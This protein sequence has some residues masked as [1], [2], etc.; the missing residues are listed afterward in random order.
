MC[1]DVKLE[2]LLLDTETGTLRAAD[3]GL[4]QFLPPG[5]HGSGAPVG[6]GARRSSAC[7]HAAPRALT[8]M[9]LPAATY[10]P[11][12][13]YCAPELL[14]RHAYGAESDCWSAG[15]LTYILLTGRPPFNGASE[16]CAGGS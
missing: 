7:A 1:L 10:I 15:V 14:L 12:A 11:Q 8:R 3:W 9:L 4:A 16:R 6:T 13:Y 5:G 2:N